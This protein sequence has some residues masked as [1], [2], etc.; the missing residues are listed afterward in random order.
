MHL[1]FGTSKSTVQDLGERGGPLFD[2]MS[3]RYS[4]KNALPFPNS[5]NINTLV[6]P[7]QHAVSGRKHRELAKFHVKYKQR[8]KKDVILMHTVRWWLRSNEE[9]EDGGAKFKVKTDDYIPA[10]QIEIDNTVCRKKFE[11]FNDL[12]LNRIC[13]W[14]EILHPDANQCKPFKHLSERQFVPLWRNMES[15][16]ENTSSANERFL[17]SSYKHSVRDEFFKHHPDSDQLGL[18][19]LKRTVL[20]ADSITAYYP[21]KSHSEHHNLGWLVNNKFDHFGGKAMP[22][23]QNSC[24]M[25]ASRQKDMIQQTYITEI[26]PV[27]KEM[28]S[29]ILTNQM[30]YCHKQRQTVIH[31]EWDLAKLCQLISPPGVHNDSIFPQQR[32]IQ[33]DKSYIGKKHSGN[34]NFVMEQMF[35]TLKEEVTSKHPVKMFHSGQFTGSKEMEDKAKSRSV[36]FYSLSNRSQSTH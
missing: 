18:A 33:I 8:C 27:K 13:D 21:C 30:K 5:K 16:D 25:N 9:V 35:S 36:E 2:G 28:W 1:C 19:I 4:N 20:S 31:R 23:S 15:I 7:E 22:R 26:F 29:K 6:R 32:S 34:T 11:N 17:T 3:K 14:K 10:L 12:W 24:S